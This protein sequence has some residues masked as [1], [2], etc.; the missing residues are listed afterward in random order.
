MTNY[1]I[2]YE[3]ANGNTKVYYTLANDAQEAIS[4][5]KNKFGK[6]ISIITVG[7]TVG[8]WA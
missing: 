7:I 4:E 1:H 5:V 3:D 8:N 2:I 6:D